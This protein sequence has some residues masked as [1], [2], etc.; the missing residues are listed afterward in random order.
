MVG[1]AVGEV[2]TSR[3]SYSYSDGCY[4]VRYS[5]RSEYVQAKALGTLTFLREDKT[6]KLGGTRAAGM[7]QGESMS[8]EH[9]CNE[10]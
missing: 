9:I 7:S 6:I 8:I 3:D 4:R 5:G 1:F 10:E 2:T